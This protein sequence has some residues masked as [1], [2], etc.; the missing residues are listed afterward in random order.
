[1]R[2]SEGDFEAGKKNKT[3]DKITFNTG[4]GQ[5]TR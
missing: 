2:K 4:E 3:A 5:C 1:L